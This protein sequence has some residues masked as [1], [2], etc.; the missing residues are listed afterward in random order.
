[1]NNLFR[2]DKDNIKNIYEQEC[3]KWLAIELQ[4]DVCLENVLGTLDFTFCDTSAKPHPVTNN[5]IIIWEYSYLVSNI[6][7]IKSHKALHKPLHTENKQVK[8]NRLIVLK[9]FKST[10]FFGPA[11]YLF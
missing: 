6:A 1:M 11:F 4:K 9:C 8:P 5:Q 10:G 7:R 2:T 3:I